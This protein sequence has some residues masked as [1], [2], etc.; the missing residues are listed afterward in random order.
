MR[1]E[2]LE[3]LVRKAVLTCSSTD[4]GSASAVRKAQEQ[5]VRVFPNAVLLRQ[6]GSISVRRLIL[7]PRAE[8]P[9][10]QQPML[11]RLIATAKRGLAEIGE[12][13]QRIAGLRQQYADPEEPELEIE[14][15][16]TAIYQR[17]RAPAAR[18][19]RAPQRERYVLTT[20]QPVLDVAQLYSFVG[21]GVA[22][23]YG[24]MQLPD[25]FASL[26]TFTALSAPAS[27]GTVIQYLLAEAVLNTGSRLDPETKERFLFWMQLAEGKV[28]RVF[29]ECAAAIR[30]RDYNFSTMG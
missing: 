25:D 3:E 26:P 27:A 12:S 20:E 17:Q 8:Q 14:A 18:K 22:V 4:W 29:Y 24:E 21:S 30:T 10:T 23:Q 1:S 19:G 9:P 16:D 15:D 13:I 7:P 28:W 6:Q 2:V 11:E 5:P